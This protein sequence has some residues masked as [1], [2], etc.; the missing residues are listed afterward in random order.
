MRVL[1]PAF[2][3]IYCVSIFKRLD[4][5]STTSII[6]LII[7]ASVLKTHPSKKFNE[8]QEKVYLLSEIRKKLSH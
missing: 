1:F 3:V 4:V 5:S 8:I 2:S 6:R 7:V